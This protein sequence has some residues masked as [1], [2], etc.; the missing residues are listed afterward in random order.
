MLYLL[1]NSISS[2]PYYTGHLHIP[3]NTFSFNTFLTNFLLFKNHLHLIRVCQSWQILN[4][5]YLSSLVNL[6]YYN[7]PDVYP[8]LYTP[9]LCFLPITIPSLQSPKKLISILCIFSSITYYHLSQSLQTV[10]CLKCKHLSSVS[11]P[12]F[13]F[14]AI[15]FA[16]LRESP[17][18]QRSNC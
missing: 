6:R 16:C 4:N 13:L 3:P 1:T 8:N 9:N 14:F 18:D 2:T 10:V 17:L 12:H 15:S 5:S 11:T 7:S